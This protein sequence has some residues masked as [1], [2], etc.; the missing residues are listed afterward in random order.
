MLD[1]D[2]LWLLYAV[3]AVQAALFAIDNP[4]RNAII[5]RLVARDALPAANALS[6]LTFNLGLTVGPLIAGLVIAAG[7]ARDRVRDRRA[8]VHGGALRAVA[9]AAAATGW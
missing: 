9:P 4:T 6:Q 5:P 3:V 2:Q 1:L 8:V 7:R